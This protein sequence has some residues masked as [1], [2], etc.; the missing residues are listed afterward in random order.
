MCVSSNQSGYSI[1][2]GQEITF[3]YFTLEVK[4]ICSSVL[5]VLFTAY[6]PISP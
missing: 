6:S 2:D 3:S 4:I 5:D 1:F